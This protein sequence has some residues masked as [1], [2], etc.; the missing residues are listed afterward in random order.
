MA[1]AGVPCTLHGVR[2]IAAI[3]CCVHDALN[4]CIFLL[5]RHPPADA[6][7]KTFPFVSCWVILAVFVHKC[8]RAVQVSFASNYGGNTI[9][10]TLLGVSTNDHHMWDYNIPAQRITADFNNDQVRGAVCVCLARLWTNSCDI[11]ASRVRCRFLFA[12]SWFGMSRPRTSRTWLTKSKDPGHPMPQS[13]L[14][15]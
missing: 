2:A 9:T 6:C 10:G 7:A 11:C 8:V 1:G 13:G 5:Q 12:V 15:A 3:L 4:N 14:R